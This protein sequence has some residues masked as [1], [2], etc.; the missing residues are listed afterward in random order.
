M[1]CLNRKNLTTAA[2]ASVIALESWIRADFRGG[3]RRGRGD[4]EIEGQLSDQS[5]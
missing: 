5:S 1:K 4:G 3:A 2:I